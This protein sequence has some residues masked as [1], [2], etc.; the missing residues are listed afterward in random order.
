[1]MYMITAIISNISTISIKLI[2]VREMDVLHAHYKDFKDALQF[3]GFR[4]SIR[5]GLHK[6][7]NKATYQCLK[8]DKP[9][10]VI[11]WP[12]VLKDRPWGR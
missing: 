3:P 4:F 7:I 2:T 6:V 1:M 8:Y 5:Q 10:I 9:I 11:L 12:C